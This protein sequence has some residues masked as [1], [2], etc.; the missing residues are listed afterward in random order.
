VSTLPRP[1]AAPARSASPYPDAELVLGR[2]A[3]IEQI[4]AGGHGTVWLARDE[5]QGRHVAVKRVPLHRGD[6]AERARVEREGRAVERLAHPAIVALLDAG[7]Q[8][9][10][11]YLVS[12]LVEG[13]SL[14]VLY[15]EGTLEDR[16]LLAIGA[17]LALALEHAHER[18]VVHRDVKPQ[19]VI[20]PARVAAGEAA[21]KLAD[22]GIARLAGEQALTNT[23]DV[24]GTFEYMAPEQAQ[25]R[26]A[27]P[28]ADL[29]ALA[30]TL[31]EGLTGANPL[32]GRTV[33]ATAMRIGS[34]IPPLGG[35]RPDLP[36]KLCRALDRA[37][38]REPARRG[39][40]EQLRAALEDSVGAERPRHRRLRRSLLVPTPKLT[41]RG[42]GL[43]AASA[44]GALAA[45]AAGTLLGVQGVA[46][47]LLA[48]AVA[49]V[50]VAI[51]AGVGWL[52]MALAAIGWLGA[53]GQPGTAVVLAA[54][55]APVPLL[56]GARPWLWSAPA[57]APL[58][59]LLGVA[60]A[61]PALAGRLGRR[62]A[63]R[64]ALGALSYWWLAVAETLSGRR[65]LFGVASG[66][67]PRLAWQD[68][69]GGAFAHALAPLCSDGR[70]LTAALW[71]LAA[72]VLPWLVRARGAKL[73]AVGALVWAAA[74]F[75]GVALI[76]DRLGVPR[77][78]LTLPAAALAGAL[79]FAAGAVA[80]PSHLPPDVA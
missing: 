56:L 70:L 6:A 29:Y 28:P 27:G 41:P 9:G 25:G 17:V 52:L 33:A 30:L 67:R 54:A 48:G 60:G 38:E 12:E 51:S 22:F 43:L 58:L 40:L 50:A 24:I 16:A 55:L 71:A 36:A 64:A 34:A 69:L 10:A 46:V 45:T 78:P 26:V 44:A 80:T 11:H 57:L 18:G 72:L 59:G 47:P 23:G 7:E 14:A 21:A 49:A 1:R 79:A 76:A 19:N 68:S 65:L 3:L 5:T 77:S 42:R 39:T 20:V 13:S 63:S 37:L 31:Y 2:Y 74:L 4:G 35:A 53:S 66:V 73:R 15:R 75:V 8:A 62:A 32:R 61:A